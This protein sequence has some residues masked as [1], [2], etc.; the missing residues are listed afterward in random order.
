MNARCG[1]PEL[2][3]LTNDIAVEIR[4]VLGKYL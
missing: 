1:M 4:D 2:M 3:C